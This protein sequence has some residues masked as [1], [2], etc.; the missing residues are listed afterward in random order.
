MPDK[1]HDNLEGELAELGSRIEYPPTPDI[2][3]TVRR[4]LDEEAAPRPGPR[5][6]LRTLARPGWAAAAAATVLLC[7]TALSPALRSTVLELASSFGSGGAS[8]AGSAAGGAGDSSPSSQESAAQETA[9]PDREGA[10]GGAGAGAAAAGGAASGSSAAGPTIAP[11]AGLGLGERL[12]PSEAQAMVGELLLP[13]APGLSA[14]RAAIYSGGP[15]E[16]GAVV[17]VFGPGSGLPPLGGA[18]AGLLLA[19]VAGDLESAYPTSDRTSGPPE[20]VDVGGR[21]GYWMPDGRA[22]RSQ[23]G[24]AENLPGGALLWERGRLVLLIRAH[25]TKEEAIR[26]ART[27]R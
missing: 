27:I 13:E 21:R 18:D 19:E 15:S 11:G 1:E 10:P 8:G 12:S 14:E 3:R 6:V 26:I 9:R 16:G 25:V 4:R 7:L 20:Q 2:A 5:R 23:P 17:L 24:E 22:L